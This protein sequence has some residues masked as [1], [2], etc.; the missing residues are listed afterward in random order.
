MTTADLAVSLDQLLQVVPRLSDQLQDLSQRQ[1]QLE[2]RMVAPSRAG[3]L[4]LAQP[5]FSTLLQVRQ[6]WRK[7]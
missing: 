7:L 4:G 2:D 6:Q 1:V 5:L 3:A